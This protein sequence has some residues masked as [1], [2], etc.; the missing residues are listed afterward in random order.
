MED[1]IKQ[2]IKKDGLDGKER[3]DY[4]N[5]KRMY[6]YYIMRRHGMIYEDIGKYFN[7]DHATVMHGVK[8]FEYLIEAKDQMLLTDIE[9]Y[10]KLFADKD[11]IKKEYNLEED[12]KNATTLGGLNIIKRRLENN[13]Y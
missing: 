12:V 7:R 1:L 11:G 10:Q 3:F 9:Y 6:L 8:R 13:L 2:V 5:N 4:L